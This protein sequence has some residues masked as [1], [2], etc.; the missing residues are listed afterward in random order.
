M[1]F[2]KGI[3]LLIGVLFV[4]HNTAIYFGLLYDY[5]LSINQPILSIGSIGS[6]AVDH[7]IV[8][9]IP[10]Y[11]FFVISIFFA[12]N[13]SKKH[14]LVV[15]LLLPAAVII[16]YFDLLHVWFYALVALIGWGIGLLLNKKVIPYLKKNRST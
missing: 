2:L 11:I 8:G 14:W 1:T 3:G 4:V 7:Y 13:F 10:A 12:I 6:Y 5:F 9:I 15:I 16:F